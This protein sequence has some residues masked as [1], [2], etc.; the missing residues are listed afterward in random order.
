VV[1]VNSFFVQLYFGPLFAVP[2]DMLG[3]KTAGLSSGFGNF[4]ANVGGFTFAYILGAVKDL[5][6]SFA[7]GFYWLAALCVIGLLCAVLLS[8]MRPVQA[9]TR[10]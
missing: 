8:R 3:T 4:F 9:A 7:L 10:A 1:G 2:I 6:G 5:T